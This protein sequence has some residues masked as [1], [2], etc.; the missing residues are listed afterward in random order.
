[1]PQWRG[2]AGPIVNDRRDPEALTGAAGMVLRTVD[3]GDGSVVSEQELDALPVF[4]GLIA[5]N[6]RL[7]LSCADGSVRCYGS[8][9]GVKANA[10]AIR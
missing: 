6:Q 5:A 2:T 4:D 1:M 10:E 7:Y 8:G 3:P 9:K